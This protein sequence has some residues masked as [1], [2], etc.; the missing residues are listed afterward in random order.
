MLKPQDL[1]IGNLVICE[2]S[3]RNT[4]SH[5][6]EVSEISKAGIWFTNQWGEYV[7]EP[8]KRLFGIPLNDAWI[9]KAGLVGLNG[10]FIFANGCIIENTIGGWSFF[11]SG[12]GLPISVI[13]DKIKYVHQLQNLFYSLSGEELAINP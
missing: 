1:R 12:I 13:T 10:I 9:L 11:I 8:Y 3:M 4:S 7:C 6:I 5:I 2:D